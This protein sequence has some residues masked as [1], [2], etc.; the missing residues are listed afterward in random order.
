MLRET[1]SHFDVVVIEIHLP[2]GRGESLLPNIEACSRQPAVILTSARGTG[3]R[4][5]ALEYRPISVTKPISPAALLRVVRTVVGGYTR[6][7]IRRFV[8]GFALSGREIEAVVLVAQGLKPKEVAQRMNCSEPTIYCHLTRASGKTGCK[9]YQEI[10]A[11]LFAFACQSVGH[12][13][14]DHRA[15]VDRIRPLAVRRLPREARDVPQ[16][17]HP[18]RFRRWDANALSRYTPS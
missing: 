17:E 10:I 14:P 16:V 3:I 9:H 7:V 18:P 13:P 2:D 4:A 1:T 15:F 11:K 5:D 6:A 8:E 12:T